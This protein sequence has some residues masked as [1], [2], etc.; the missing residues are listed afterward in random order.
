MLTNRKLH[1]AFGKNGWAGSHKPFC[2]N[3]P[4]KATR[5]VPV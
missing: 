4:S 5:A 1:D 2:K 3:L